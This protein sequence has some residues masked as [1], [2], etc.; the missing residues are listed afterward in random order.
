MQH[1]KIRTTSAATVLAIATTLLFAQQ[2]SRISVY[3]PGIRPETAA[4]IQAEKAAEDAWFAHI[5]V[6]AGDDLKGRRTG[7]PDFIHA[8]EYVESQYKAIGLKPAGTDGYRQS[9]GFRSASVDAE[10]SSLELVHSDG[11][12]QKLNIG[13]EATL[14]PNAEGAVSV[15]APAVFAGY[16]LVVPGLGL[17]DAKAIDLHG[18]I[19]VILLSSPAS[20]HGP[21]KAYFRTAGARWKALKAAGAVGLITIPEARQFAGGAGRGTG[22]D[23][24]LRVAQFQRSREDLLRQLVPRKLPLVER[25]LCS[26]KARDKELVSRVSRA[27]NSPI[28]CSIRSRGRG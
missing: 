4:S 2:H 17:N 28:L 23:V 19:A 11:Q 5:Q 7:T 16:G 15:S 8:V 10:A 13:R 18:K 3:D 22:G 27:S 24:Q 20:V 21:L 9:V 12:T 25:V 26:R 14:S 1:L 6:L